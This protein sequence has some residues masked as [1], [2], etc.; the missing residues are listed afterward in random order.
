VLVLVM[1]VSLPMQ[2]Q[3]CLATTFLRQFHQTKTLKRL[4]KTRG[5]GFLIMIEMVTMMMM[6]ML[7]PMMM[8]VP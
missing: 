4:R 3:V 7:M 6:V 5:F 2:V 8:Y 1:E